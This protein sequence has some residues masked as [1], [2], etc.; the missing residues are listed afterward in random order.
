MVMVFSRISNGVPSSFGLAH[1]C[2]LGDERSVY[3]LLAKPINEPASSESAV[4]IAT[5]QAFLRRVCPVSQISCII[6]PP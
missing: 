5:G 1:V 3:R 4:P 6:P 2:R